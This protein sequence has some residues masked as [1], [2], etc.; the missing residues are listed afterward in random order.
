MKAVRFYAKEDVRFDEVP[1]PDALGDSQVLVRPLTCGICGT[2]LHEFAGGPIVT[3]IN[4]H[5]F[6]GATLPQILGHEFSAEVVETGRSVSRV[7]KGDRVSIQPLVM[8]LDDYYSRRGLNH[9]SP[10]MGCIGLSWAWGGMGE[11]AVIN[12]YNAN[13]IPDDVSD[14][15]GAMVEPTAVALYGVDRAKIKGGDTVLVT[16]AGPIGALVI[17]IC[18]A[19]GA[20]K[21]FV[22]EPN[23]NRR[24]HIESLGVAAAVLDPRAVN[25]VDYIRE[26]TEEGV[27]VDA[28]I[29]CSG[30]ELALNTCVE[31][32]RNHGTVVQ[33]GLHVKKALVDPALWA[34][35]DITIE[36]TW[37]Y[38]VTMW[39]RV[40][41]MISSGKLP[42]EK[43]ITGRIQPEAD[44]REGLPLAAEPGG[45]GNEGHGQHASDPSD[46]RSELM[47][48]EALVVGATGIAGRGVSQELLQVGARVHGLSRKPEGLA[49]GATHVAAD[50][51]DAAS[52]AQGAC[53]L[54]AEPRLSDHMVATG[55]R[56]GEHPGQCRG[57][58]DAARVPSRPPARCAMSRS[59]PASS[60][61]SGRSTPM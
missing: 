5:K 35:K 43:I 42:V 12:D 36:A 17:L 29:E 3:P 49:P 28:A 18:N 19:V 39:P 25:V 2:D 59:S 48:I 53:G 4:P 8:P 11:L 44:R 57:G 1:A 55:E 23:A 40:I 41:R 45:P 20:S 33:T 30:V 9:L 13:P 26:N 7:R 60:I 52:V 15:Q 31:A 58:A 14:E 6:T 16:G 34:L 61:I 50:L 22:S 27:G 38:E 21:I 24:R 51:T 54:E 32:V 37:C 10:S 46:A 47:Q 56:R